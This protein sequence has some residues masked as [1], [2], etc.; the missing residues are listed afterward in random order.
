LF[1]G[2]AWAAP[3]EQEIVRNTVGGLLLQAR[4]LRL[5][6]EAAAVARLR[7]KDPFRR[8]DV[9]PRIAD[10]SARAGAALRRWDLVRTG[11]LFQTLYGCDREDVVRALAAM[12]CE[13]GDRAAFDSLWSSKALSGTRRAECWK[14]A[15]RRGRGDWVR[16]AL[17]QEYEKVQ[18][19]DDEAVKARRGLIYDAQ[20]VALHA[21]FDPAFYQMAIGWMGSM[22]HPRNLEYHQSGVGCLLQPLRE[23]QDTGAVLSA[24]ER[25]RLRGMPQTVAFLEA[26]RGAGDGC[27]QRWVGSA[28]LASVAES[29]WELGMTERARAATIELVRGLPRTPMPGHLH[30]HLYRLSCA[31]RG[32][33]ARREMTPEDAQGLWQAASEC[34]QPAARLYL[35]AALA[36]ALLELGQEREALH[37]VS[38]LRP[39]ACLSDDDYLMALCIAELCGVVGLGGS[40]RAEALIEE[41]LRLAQCMDTPDARCDAL[42]PLVR[43][44][45][46]HGQLQRAEAIAMEAPTWMNR[47]ELHLYIAV[48][49]AWLG[50]AWAERGERTEALRMFAVAKD[51][52]ESVPTY[53]SSTE[54]TL[55]ID[56]LI[57]SA[58]ASGD[59][60]YLAVATQLASKWWRD[61][62]EAAW[63]AIVAVAWSE[64]GRRE[65]ALH[66]LTRECERRL[67]VASYAAM[68]GLTVLLQGFVW[69]NAREE[70]ATML[71]RA[72]QFAATDPP[73]IDV[74][75]ILL[76]SLYQPIAFYLEWRARQDRNPSLIFW[77]P[78]FLEADPEWPSPPLFA[79]ALDAARD[80]YELGEPRLMEVAIRLGEEWERAC[81][82]GDRGGIES[83]PGDRNGPFPAICRYGARLGDLRV[84]E[85]LEEIARHHPKPECKALMYMEL[86][87]GILEHLGVLEMTEPDL[88]FSF[89]PHHL[90]SWQLRMVDGRVEHRLQDSSSDFARDSEVPDPDDE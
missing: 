20:D 37:L 59:S 18:G 11:E 4:A 78:R 30:V 81:P 66:M 21:G 74:D 33:A 79:L 19:M 7:A 8:Y 61:P 36:A 67:R 88:G 60:Q 71:Q 31:I 3:P 76:R 86:A 15:V 48:W 14:E 39:S 47:E 82:L 85:H 56:N 57:A 69:L 83:T 41:C 38:V 5:L 50:Q 23:R 73:L 65:H 1:V 26:V 77:I 51:V 68:Q 12:A 80:A 44:L 13:T 42:H 32:A 25:I 55:L 64:L 9:F 87:A 16:E 58:R 46:G 35:N 72:I 49:N 22:M 6:D 52:A 29:Y 75:P 27:T 84:L 10:V 43:Y 40:E 34:C 45:I 2:I 17:L 54:R 24:D 70:Y 90:D 89:F 62:Q 28:V 53:L 63:L